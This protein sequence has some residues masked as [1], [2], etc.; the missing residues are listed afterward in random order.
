MTEKSFL[1]QFVEFQVAYA[2]LLATIEQYPATLQ[3]Q[4]GITD[5]WSAREVIAHING[6]IA[7]ALRRL[8]RFATG[9]GHFE[10]NIDAFNAVSIWSR[11]GKDFDQLTEELKRLIHKVH[12]FVADIDDLYTGRDDR[13]G[14][15]LD[16]LTE[17]AN[18][19]DAELR[20]FLDET[21]S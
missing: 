2:G 14:E 1:E 7:E 5:D 16:I 11:E 10:Y 4:I 3:T 8:P 13:Y 12:I 6:W 20:Q 19:H 21:A 17:Q 15:W 18:L 9:T